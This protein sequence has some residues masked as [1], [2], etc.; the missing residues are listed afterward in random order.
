LECTIPWGT[1]VYIH[2]FHTIRARFKKSNGIAAKLEGLKLW[3]FWLVVLWAD[4]ESPPV[5]AKYVIGITLSAVITEAERE[6]A[7]SKGHI[8]PPTVA[9]KIFVQFL[10]LL[11][12]LVP[13]LLRR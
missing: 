8:I 4:L 12:L 1:N 10:Y 6:F 9:R 2:R 3:F 13:T 7:G 5:F 11:R